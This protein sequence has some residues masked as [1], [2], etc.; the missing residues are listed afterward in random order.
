MDLRLATIDVWDVSRRVFAA[1]IPSP[2][3]NSVAGRRCDCSWGY[4]PSPRTR[5]ILT[6]LGATD[7]DAD[8]IYNTCF[9]LNR[10]DHPN[11]RSFEFPKTSATL[12]FLITEAERSGGQDDKPH[13]L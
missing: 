11:G 8:T 10:R 7:V 9:Q 2:T 5:A 1:F 3:P 4:C 6:D 13:L 12:A